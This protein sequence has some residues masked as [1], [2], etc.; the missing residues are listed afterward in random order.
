MPMVQDVIQ[1]LQG[2]QPDEHIA[3]AIWCEED[4]I[5]LAQQEM[6]GRS[7]EKMHKLYSIRLTPTR[8]VSWASTGTLYAVASN[9][10]RLNGPQPEEK[11]DFALR[12]GLVT[13]T[14]LEWN[15]YRKGGSSISQG[16]EN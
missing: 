11:R 4:V 6:I 13:R 2:Y 7:A 3:V 14:R 12:R 16:G 5:L 8:T 1:R 9:C 10:I 15:S